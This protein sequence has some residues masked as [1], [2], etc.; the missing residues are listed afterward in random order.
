MLSRLFKKK[1]KNEEGQALIEFALSLPILMLFIA[2]I[3]DFGVILFSYSQASNSLR[4]ALRYSEI[5]W[6]YND[7]YK[8]YLDCQ[9]MADTVAD[10]Y[11]RSSYNL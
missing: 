4:T 6:Y 5:Y 1:R 7:G 11:F 2:G 9:G 3:I 10:N 8:P